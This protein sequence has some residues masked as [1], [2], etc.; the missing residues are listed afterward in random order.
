MNPKLQKQPHQKFLGSTSKPTKSIEKDP[1]LQLSTTL[2]DW[3]DNDASEGYI[4]CDFY[5]FLFFPSFHIRKY[6]KHTFFFR[7]FPLIL[8]FWSFVGLF[9]QNRVGIDIEHVLL[10]TLLSSL[11]CCAAF[12]SGVSVNFADISGAE[13]S[14]TELEL[15]RTLFIIFQSRE[16]TRRK[17]NCCYGF[18]LYVLLGIALKLEH[19]IKVYTNLLVTKGFCVSL[20]V[21]VDLSILFVLPYYQSSFPT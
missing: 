9:K 18:Y 16:E 17:V 7:I 13:M 14:W 5:R 21:T 4:F 2:A 1:T 15:K 20:S 10:Y 19:N 11:L 12:V 8:G 6:I 3:Y